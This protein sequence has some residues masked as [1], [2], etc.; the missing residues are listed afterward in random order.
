MFKAFPGLLWCSVCLLQ[1]AASLHSWELC[2][3]LNSQPKNRIKILEIG[4]GMGRQASWIFRQV[5][6]Q[7]HGFGGAD[8]QEH[9]SWRQAW[10]AHYKPW[11]PF[12]YGSWDTAF[13]FSFRVCYLN[14]PA[15]GCLVFEESFKIPSCPIYV[16]GRRWQRH[17]PDAPMLKAI[18]RWVSTWFHLVLQ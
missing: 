9:L 5:V 15:G 7:S 14:P 2:W 10:V 8:R 16:L 18:Q 6:P 3:H 12:N 17:F 1:F 13:T 11:W 4:W